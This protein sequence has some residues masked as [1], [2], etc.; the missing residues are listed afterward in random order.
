MTALPASEA[1]GVDEVVNDDEA[2]VTYFDR[3][4]DQIELVVQPH[5]EKTVA[6]RVDDR[7]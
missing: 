5:R 2:A 4:G 7:C 6:L 3:P 1:G